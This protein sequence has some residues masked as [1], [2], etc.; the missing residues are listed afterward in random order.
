M[1]LFF[2]VFLF[3]LFVLVDIRCEFLMVVSGVEVR[4]VDVV[5]SSLRRFIVVDL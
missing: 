1:F 4:M 3:E 5:I 2:W